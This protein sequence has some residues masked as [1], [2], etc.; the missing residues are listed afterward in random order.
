MKYKTHLKTIICSQSK[1]IYFRLFG[2][3]NIIRHSFYKTRQGKRR[4]Y[5]CKECEKTFT[6]GAAYYRLQKSKASFDNI[7]TLMNEA[8][9][10]YEIDL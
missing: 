4:R 5:R 2:K 9:V 10:I 1:C 6:Y 8:P 7:A 3:G